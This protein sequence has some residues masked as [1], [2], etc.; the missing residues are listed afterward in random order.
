LILNVCTKKEKKSKRFAC[1]SGGIGGTIRFEVR[2]SFA[3][4]AVDGSVMNKENGG[5]L[6][7][8]IC[9]QLTHNDEAVW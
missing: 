9:F 1:V 2:N 4:M 3:V 6:L 8:N 7:R 5:E